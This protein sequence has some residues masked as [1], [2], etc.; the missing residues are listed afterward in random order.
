MLTRLSE[1]EK[2]GLDVR[3]DYASLWRPLSLL[4]NARA[5]SFCYT[6]QTIWGTFV[7]L[8]KPHVRRWLGSYL[9]RILHTYAVFAFP[10]I[11]LLMR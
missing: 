2:W 6:P 4:H 7:A 3:M 5:A 11:W 10:L 1:G 9:F 8:S